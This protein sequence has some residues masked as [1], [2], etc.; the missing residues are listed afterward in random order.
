MAANLIEKLNLKQNQ[1]ILILNKPND[2]HEFDDLLFDVKVEKKQYNAIISFIFSIDEFIAN[3]KNTI[4]N[5]LLE[6]EGSIY[7]IYPKKG[8]KKY[9]RYIG[10]DDFFEPAEMN[11]DGYVF[12]SNLKFYKMLAFDE[13]FTLIGLKNSTKKQKAIEKPSQLIGDYV[14]KVTDIQQHFAE[15]TTVLS[16]YN[17][18]TL[19][20][21]RGWARYVYS[22]KS[23]ETIKKRF[24]K[25]ETILREGYKSIDLYRRNKK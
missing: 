25:M 14:D 12:G 8:N 4:R 18:L 24:A 17:K 11:E 23:E 10:R 7:F 15:N 1:V 9:D 21:Q 5:E 6:L 19:G 22:T 3:L 2:I 13:T 16:I 20:Y